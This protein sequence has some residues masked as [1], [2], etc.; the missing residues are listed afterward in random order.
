MYDSGKIKKIFN[1]ENIETYIIAEIGINHNGNIDTAIE[2]IKAA[3]EAG[4]DAVKFQKRD[5]DNIYSE[6][7]INNENN[8]EW[9]F[10]YL[11]PLLKEIELSKDDYIQ[12]RNLCDELELDLIVTPFDEKSAE[13]LYE[14]G[15]SAY[16]ISSADMTNIPLLLKCNKFNLPLIISTGMWSDEDIFKCVNIYKANKLS[17]ALLLAQSTYPASYETLNLKYLERLKDFTSVI[18]YS[19]HERGTFIPV[20]AVAM[21]CKIIEKHITFDITQKGPDHKASMLP[22]EWKEMVFQIRMLEKAMGG[23]RTKHVNQA[24][25]QNKEAFAKSAVPVRDLPVGHILIE[26]DLVYKA[27]GK[28]IFAHEINDYI[29]KVLKRA[30][31]KDHYIGKVDFEDSIAIKDWQRFYFS[32]RWGIKCRFHDYNEYKILNSPCIEFHCSQTDLDIDFNPDTSQSELIVHAPEIFDRQLVNICS[33][34]VDIVERSLD[35]LQRSIDKTLSI[36]RHFPKAKPKLVMH[37]GGMFLNTRQLVNTSQ[38]TEIAIKNFKKLKYNSSQID[39]IPENLPPRPWYLGGEWFQHG[40]MLP[41]DMLAFCNYFGLGMTY[42]IC[43]ASLYCNEFGIDLADYTEEVMPI[44]KHIHISDAYGNNGEGVQIGE[45]C[46]D[47][48]R[49]LK[50]VEKYNFTWVPEIW[51]GHLHQGAGTYKCMKILNEKY[52]KEL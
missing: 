3:K 38:L 47:F 26:S 6:E 18:G 9:N 17:Y 11:I 20:A 4:V 40:F 52:S 1:N 5:L 29:G 43:H 14:L 28:G 16:K 12:I 30:I 46:I 19:G 50:K 31:K 23:T 22:R 45:G 7:V 25:M 44:V 37:L 2:L 39:I 21:G 35:I 34:S 27:P 24:E 15:I 41:K 8:S 32:K 13:F 49:V 33:N 51:S 36:S 48:G 10:E 42:D